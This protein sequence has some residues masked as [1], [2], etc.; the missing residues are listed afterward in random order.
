MGYQGRA[1]QHRKSQVSRVCGFKE[2]CC[3][4][5][6][7]PRLEK[8]LLHRVCSAGTVGLVLSRTRAL[9]YQRLLIEAGIPDIFMAV[10]NCTDQLQQPGSR[11]AFGDTVYHCF[12]NLIFLFIVHG[13]FGK[14]WLWS[15]TPWSGLPFSCMFSADGEAWPGQFFLKFLLES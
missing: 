3:R 14:F 4:F 2:K 5:T 9:A 10:S 12:Q 1:S 13:K 6:A 8:P 15:E 11:F 7:A